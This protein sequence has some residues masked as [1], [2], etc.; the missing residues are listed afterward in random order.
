MRK[1]I[2]PAASMQAAV[3]AHDLMCACLHQC[4]QHSKTLLITC[5]FLS[6]PGGMAKSAAAASLPCDILASAGTPCVA[7]HST[8]RALFAN[9]YG[10]LYQVQRSSD[11]TYLNVQTLTTGGYASAASQDSFCANT[12]CTI[13]KIYDQTSYHND[14][15]IEGPGQR[16]GQDK[17]ASATALPVYAGGD[18]VYG[19]YISA[20]MGYRNNS[21]SGVATNGAPEGMYIV[22][23]GTHYNGSCCFDYGN[24]ETNERDNGDAHMDALNFSNE[25]YYSCYGSGPWVQADLENGLYDSNTGKSTDSGNTGLTSPFVTAVLLNNAQTNFVLMGGNAQSGGLTTF[26]SGGLPSGYSPLKQEGAIVLGT[27]GDNSDGSIG[28]FFE[29]VMTSGEPSASSMNSVQSNIVSVGYSTTG[30][31]GGGGTGTAIT[32]YIYANGAWVQESTAT[33][34]S[35][36]TVDLGPQ[37]VSGGS[38]SWTGPNGFTSTA[39]ELDG[40]ALSVGTNTYVATYTNSSNVKST[41][42]FTITVTGGGG[43]TPTAITPY[44]QVNGAGWQQTNVATV[45]SGSTV[46]LGPQPTSG[47]SW[48]WTGPNGYTSTARQI[49]GIPLSTGADVYTATYTNSSSCKS[50]EPFTI[51][52]N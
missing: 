3:R 47:G 26:Y 24:A 34:A 52:V 40:I 14:L 16:A 22:T 25:C 11:S 36:A 15:S 19:V 6:I 45:A 20:G 27:G 51:T 5:I 7:A 21:T 2:V 10:S 30:T 43:C 9:F 38:W 4:L 1:S 13:T 17:G 31:G 18:K 28:S 44:L 41:E 29:G 32:P 37:P 42:T 50:T 23:S 12:S 35:G 46:N 48:S 8:T 39:R 49:N 33:V